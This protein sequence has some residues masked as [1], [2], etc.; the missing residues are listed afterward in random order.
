MEFWSSLTV[1]VL[2]WMASEMTILPWLGY[3]LPERPAPKC[4]VAH[5]WI[6]PFMALVTFVSFPGRRSPR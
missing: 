2:I 4:R 1:C 5:H 6:F 3:G